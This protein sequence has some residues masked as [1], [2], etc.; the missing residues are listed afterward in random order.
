M[1]F[2]KEQGKAVF[3]PPFPAVSLLCAEGHKGQSFCA[4]S[5]EQ[6]TLPKALHLQIETFPCFFIELSSACG[7]GRL[8]LDA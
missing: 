1:P 6:Q 5:K 3:F 4:R 7:S 8:R 2:R